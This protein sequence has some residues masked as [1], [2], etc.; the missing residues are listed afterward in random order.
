MAVRP[1]HAESKSW[2][3]PDHAR[4]RNSSHPRPGRHASE[5]IL[6]HPY[7]LRMTPGGSETS[8]GPIIQLKQAAATNNSV[9]PP[10]T[11]HPDNFYSLR[12]LG[13]ARRGACQR[14]P[15]LLDN[16]SC[17]P[18]F[19]LAS[20]CTAGTRLRA[21]RKDL[22]F[23]RLQHDEGRKLSDRVV[24]FC[25]TPRL[26][27]RSNHFCLPLWAR[28]RINT[29]GTVIPFRRSRFIRF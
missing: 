13:Q 2:R 12:S 9:Y 28:S 6:R 10:H 3:K 20:S 24:G 15:I 16:S 11:R 25:L 5:Q 21:V 18:R 7:R 23:G 17:L 22:F 4:Q 1:I 14:K 19:R 26:S 8:S 29:A 27:G